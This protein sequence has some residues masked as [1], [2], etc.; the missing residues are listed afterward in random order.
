MEQ[1]AFNI[2]SIILKEKISKLIKSL[3]NNKVLGLNGILN[4]FFKIVALVIIKDLVK[5]ASYYFANKIIPKSL[6]KFIIMVLYKKEKKN[7]FLGGYKLITFKNTLVKIL[8]KYIVN[9]ILKAVKKYKL[10]LWN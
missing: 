3:L 7:S 5:T 4:K 2:S 6:K 1:R 9:I 8:E 10:F